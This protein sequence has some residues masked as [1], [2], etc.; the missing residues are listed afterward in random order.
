[1]TTML[2]SVN[3]PDIVNMASIAVN[4]KLANW[5]TN[6]MF[7]DTGPLETMDHLFAD[8]WQDALTQI[9][10]VQLKNKKPLYGCCLMKQHSWFLGIFFRLCCRFRSITSAQEILCHNWKRV[11][12]LRHNCVSEVETPK[13]L[14]S[15]WWLLMTIKNHF[16]Y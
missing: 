14:H 10:P 7:R 5:L 15:I 16:I 1:M 9:L 4:A 3:I 13:A 11:M 6:N 2:N 12:L 8:N